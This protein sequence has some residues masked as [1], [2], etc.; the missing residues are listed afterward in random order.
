M[1]IRSIVNIKID[2]QGRALIPKKLRDT[3][4][5]ANGEDLIGWLDGERLVLESR[6]ALLSRMQE[7]YSGLEGSLADELIEERRAEAKSE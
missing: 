7:R 1:E 5:V 6:Y 3:L 4:G 2:T